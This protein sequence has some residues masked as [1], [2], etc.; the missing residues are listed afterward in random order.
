MS[1]TALTEKTAGTSAQIGEYCGVQTAH[2]FGDS[3][4]EFQALSHSCG[5]YDLGWRSKIIVSGKDRTRWLNGMITN[6]IR[7]LQPNHGNYSFVLSPQGRIQGDLYAYNRGDYIVLGSER[8][9]TAGIFERLKKYIIMDKVEL[10]DVSDRLTAVGVQGPKSFEVLRSAGLPVP[11][12]QPM[13]IAD[14]TW[15]EIGLSITRMANDRFL[16][17][18]IWAST[19]NVGAIWDAVVSAGATPVGTDALEMFRIAA[20]IPRYGIDISDRDLPQETAQQQ[21]LNFS[22]GCY[23]GQEIVERIRAR[24]NVHRT[25]AG[26]VIEDPTPTKGKIT[27]NGKEVGELTSALS[28]PSDPT[29][30]VLGLGIIR[31]EAADLGTRVA[32]G[33]VV[34]TVAA[35]PFPEANS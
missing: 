30:R 29:D 21:A 7:D 3:R 14:A 4:R 8:S 5:I 33:N 31:R 9:Q 16:T 19:E 12:V 18:E 35:L 25:L 34:A 1:T 27:V 32:I 28:I 23:I 2:S 26:F 22:K 10:E 17:Y 6:N 15:R 13:E 24:G 11:D 20:G